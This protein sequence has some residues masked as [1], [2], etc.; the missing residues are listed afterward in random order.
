MSSISLTNL[1][2]AIGGQNVLTST[3]NMTYENFLEQVNLSEQLTS[4]DFG[5]STKTQNRDSPPHPPPTNRT[6]ANAP[7]PP[8][9]APPHPNACP[10]QDPVPRAPHSTAHPRRGCQVERDSETERERGREGESDR[11]CASNQEG[12]ETGS[13]ETGRERGDRKRDEGDTK[14]TRTCT[15]AR[16]LVGDEVATMNER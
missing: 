3:L 14:K 6:H 10:L 16:N 5:V 8:A 11:I 13:G 15:C 9:N 7:S 12:G 4:S 1:Q 2:V